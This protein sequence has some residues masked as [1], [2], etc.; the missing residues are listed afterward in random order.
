[1]QFFKGKSYRG[2]CPL[3][4]WLTM[5]EPNE[6]ALLDNL[7]LQL[8]VNDEVRQNDTTA[9]LVFKPWETISELSTFANIAPGDVLLTGTPNGCALR[10]PPPMIRRVLQLLPERK[11]WELFVS[12]QRRRPEYLKPGD[13]VAATI[14]SVDGRLD[15][16]EQRITVA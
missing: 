13:S 14:R 1:M 4:P 8:R 10:V 15:L 16:G 9:N 12:S 3:G 11:F 6:F 5:L 7:D 2:F